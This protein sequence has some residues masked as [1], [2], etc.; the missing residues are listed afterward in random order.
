MGK[1]PKIIDV[2]RLVVLTSENQVL[3]VM[4]RLKQQWHCPGG[5]VKTAETTREAALREAWEET[6]LRLTLIRQWVLSLTDTRNSKQQERI[7]FYLA[8]PKKLVTYA[9]PGRR[10][11]EKLGFFTLA[12]MQGMNLTDTTREAIHRIEFIGL[13]V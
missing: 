7:S 13:F 2:A 5:I 6:G 4:P 10:E 1:V 3:L 11:I 8:R 12:E 9:K